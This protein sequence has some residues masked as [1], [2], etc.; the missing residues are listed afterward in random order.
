M[1][2]L[3]TNVVSELRRAAIGKAD[4]NVVAW[5]AS[6]PVALQ[7][8]SALTVFELEYGVRLK[9]H[10]DPAQGATLRRWL[11]TQVLPAFE[12][13]TL[14]IDTPVALRCAPMHVPN[15]CKERDSFIAATALVRG[16]T[17]VTR[18]VTD[19]APTGAKLFNP[20][21]WRATSSATGAA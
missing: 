12:G 15:P 4:A 8:I 16:M 9:E 14:A 6:V 19:F 1:F 20:W 11:E 18:D 10:S 17:V 13:R 21:G 5:A 2:L 3:D 7:F